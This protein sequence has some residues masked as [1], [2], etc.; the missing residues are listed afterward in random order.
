MFQTQ[1]AA[2][3]KA[4]GHERGWNTRGTKEDWSENGWQVEAEEQTHKALLAML[5]FIFSLKS[6]RKSLVF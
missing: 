1:E 5:S 4:L 6:I 3:P 2:C